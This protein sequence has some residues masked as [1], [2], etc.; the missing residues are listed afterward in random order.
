[1]RPRLHGRGSAPPRASAGWDSAPWSLTT[2]T[3]GLGRN[4]N[5][6]AAT[7]YGTLQYV[8]YA[9]VRPGDPLIEP[10]KTPKSNGLSRLV[11]RHGN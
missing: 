5:H 3:L 8:Q 7:C 1:M 2:Q 9:M 4:C 10:I 6:A 11:I